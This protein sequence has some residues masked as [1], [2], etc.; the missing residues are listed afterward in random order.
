MKTMNKNINPAAMVAM[1]NAMTQ[2]VEAVQKANSALCDMLMAHEDVSQQVVVNEPVSEPAKSSEENPKPVKTRIAKPSIVSRPSEE[3]AKAYD[4]LLFGDRELAEWTGF[5][6]GNVIGWK[7]RKRDPIPAVKDFDLSLLEKEVGRPVKHVYSKKDVLSWLKTKRFSYRSRV[8]E[9]DS[10]SG[11]SAA[12]IEI[13]NNP[14][15]VMSV[16][17]SINI[18]AR[19]L[20]KS[21]SKPSVTPVTVRHIQDPDKIENNVLLTVNQIAEVMGVND[22]TV[23]RW[24]QKP[25]FPASFPSFEN[26]V[27]FR[28][29][30]FGE[31]KAWCKKNNRQTDLEE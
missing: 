29:F 10:D 26:G 27:Q 16:L 18:T 5:A 11:K 28:R 9:N 2:M 4:D 20:A 12:T 14:S 24:A 22:R 21:L 8:Q 25:S 23:R 3:R 19:K 7:H 1:M 13:S 17:S 30:R 6:L 15:N 31:V